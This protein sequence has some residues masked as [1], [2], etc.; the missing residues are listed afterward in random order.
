MVFG[1]IPLTMGIN[2]FRELRATGAG[3]LSVGL[4]IMSLHGLAPAVGLTMDEHLWGMSFF[5]NSLGIL[6]LA[7]YLA[8]IGT[9][10]ACVHA[11]NR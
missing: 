1:I 9:A 5:A 8:A 3:V 4:I 11:C 2:R 10:T 7:L 6:W